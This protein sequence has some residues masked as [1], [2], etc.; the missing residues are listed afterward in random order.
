MFEL[1]YT[2]RRHL[3][4]E[5]PCTKILKKKIRVLS[6]ASRASRP[7]FVFTE[8]RVF[9]SIYLVVMASNLIGIASTL[10]A[11]ASNLLAMAYASTAA[12]MPLEPVSEVLETDRAGFGGVRP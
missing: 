1:S 10:R 11:M 8:W 2:L 4:C 12:S 7:F 5:R 9:F 3:I 6:T